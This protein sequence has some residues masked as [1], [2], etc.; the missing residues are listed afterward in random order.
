MCNKLDLIGVE[1]SSYDIVT[2]SE[3]GL[4]AT[5]SNTDLLLPT[6]PPPIHLDRNGHCGGVAIYLKKR[7]PF[8][9]RT[10]LTIPNLEPIWVEV[11]LCNKKV[12]IGKFY[13]NS[14]F[15]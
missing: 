6:F 3:T 5:I 13:I 12:I 2:V 11:N 10:D 15:T 14:R 7:I 8:I 4:D 1:L 9:E